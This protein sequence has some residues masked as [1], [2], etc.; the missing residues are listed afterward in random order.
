MITRRI[1]LL[2]AVA[3][4]TVLL[5]SAAAIAQDDAPEPTLE[6][7]LAGAGFGE[8][9]IVSGTN[10][11]PNSIVQVQTCGNLG[12]NGTSDCD[13]I[14]TVQAGVNTAGTFAA[15]M[16]IGNPPVPCPCVFLVTSQSSGLVE[17]LEFELRGAAVSDDEPAGIVLPE[18]RLNISEARIEG[19]GPW[20]ALFGAPPQRTFVLTIVNT[21]AVPVNNPSIVLGLGKGADPTGFVAAPEID[22]IEPGESVTV[23]VP[24]ELPVMAIGT[25]AVV[26]SIPGF[27]TP[28]EFRAETSQI[29]W[30]LLLIPVL[31]LVQVGLLAIRNRVRARLEERDAALRPVVVAAPEVPA[32]PRTPEELAVIDLREEE[33]I[34]VDAAWDEP[35]P[36]EEPVEMDETVDAVQHHGEPDTG[37]ADTSDA[38]TSSADTGDA[39]TGDADT[40]ELEI[41]IGEELSAVFD[42]AFRQRDDS[43]D[44]DAFRTLVLDLAAT[45]AG[46]VADRAPLEPDE[47]RALDLE[48]ADAVLG[49]FGLESAAVK[50]TGAPP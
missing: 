22:R 13:Q 41:I 35:A 8:R 40:G 30:L 31:I 2:L 12:L 5:S 28:I 50:T 29:P 6:S 36:R 45:A 14:T 9:V 11:P 1:A 21:G 32:P 34:D 3:A 26:G 42:E 24:L 43:I 18:R 19:S 17:S 39:D 37:D 47:R 38:D 10:W 4:A 46:R 20:T 27:D 7:N 44:D 33:P 16:L 15:V 23:R 49:A 48:M 25:Y